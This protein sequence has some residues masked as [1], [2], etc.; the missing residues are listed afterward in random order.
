MPHIEIYWATP[1]VFWP[2]S[3]AWIAKHKQPLQAQ[4]L[5]HGVSLNIL[6]PIDTAL[7]QEAASAEAI[8]LSNVAM[9]KQ[10]QAVI[11]DV[12]PFRSKEPDVGTALKIGI[13]TH[14]QKP[15]YLYSSSAH[16]SLQDAYQSQMNAQGYVP[17]DGKPTQVEDFGHPVN[18]MLV[19]DLNGNK[20]TV[21]DSLQ[22]ALTACLQDW[23]Q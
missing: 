17:F 19:Y 20:R 23:I 21:H 3:E 10:A 4:A 9:I 1:A 2:E 8:F 18:L 6:S 22:D 5:A 15:V 13:A 14:M 16:L 11:A 12:S 7:E